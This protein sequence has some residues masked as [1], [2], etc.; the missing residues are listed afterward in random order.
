MLGSIPP[1][2]TK[3]KKGSRWDPFLYSPAMGESSTEGGSTERG[4]AREMPS[5]ARPFHPAHEVRPKGEPRSGESIPP[6]TTKQERLVFEGPFSLP[7]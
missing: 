7:V 1:I 5:E 3:Y 2:T 6:V 4:A